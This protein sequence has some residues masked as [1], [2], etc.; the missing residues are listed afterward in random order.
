MLPE[1]VAAIAKNRSGGIRSVVDHFRNARNPRKFGIA[2]GGI[3]NAGPAAGAPSE[4][5]LR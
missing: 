5:A 3:V 4:V 2:A 1:F